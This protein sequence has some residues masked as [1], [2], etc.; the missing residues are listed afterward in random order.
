MEE[1][2]YGNVLTG[3]STHTV[4]AARGSVGTAALQGSNRTITLAAGV[5]TFSGLSYDTAEAM[6]ILFTTNASAVTSATSTSVVVA[7]AA[8]SKL[9]VTQRPSGTATAG[10]AFT[11]QP[12]V[13]EEDQ[14]GNIITTD[15][16]DTVTA[17]RG[18]VGTASLQGSNLTVTLVNGV[19][20]FSGLSYNI[21]ETMNIGFTTNA[22][23]VSAAASGNIAVSP[24]AA[25]QLVINQQPSPTAIAG[26]PFSTQPV[27]YEED[28]YNNLEKG[29]NSTVI[30]AALNSGSGP[31]GGTTTATVSG[32]IAKF[33]NLSDSTA[34][35]ITLTFSSSTLTSPAS[36]PVVVSPVTANKL[37]IH[38]QPSATATAGQAFAIQPVI[39][40]EDSSGNLLTS[41]NTSVVTVS[42]AS[43]NGTL[44]GTKQV[45]AEGG[46]VT[47]AGLSD[48]TA[49]TISLT[50]SGDGLTAGPSTNITV[51]PAAASKLVITQEPSATAT[52]GQPFAT[53]PVIYEEDQYGNVITTDSTDTVTAARGTVGTASLHGSNLTITLVNG[54]ATLSGLS[55][56]IAETMNIAFSTNASGVSAAASGNIAVS[57]AAASQLVINQQPSLAATVGQPFSTQPVIYEEDQYN[58]LEKS[59]DSTV[60]TVKL[61]SGSG[62]LAGATTA[63]VS[64][65][66]AQ[67]TNLAD[68][69][70]ETITLKFSSSTLTSPASNPVVVSPVTANKLLIHLQPS[71][72]ATAGQAFAIQPVIYLEDSSGNLLTSDNTSVVTVSL[73]SGNGT[74]QGTKQVTAEG[75][76]VTFEG[77]SDNTAGTISLS[78]SG[79]GLTA[80]PSTNITVNPAAASKLVITQEP[81]ATAT[82]G[83]VFSTEPVVEEEDQYGNV[84]TTDSTDTVTAARGTVGTASLQGSNLTVTLVNGVASFS[85]LSYN[86]AE[87]MNIG[88][89]TNASG[90]SAA[91]SD[92]IVVSPAAASQLVINQQ[93]SPTA[94]AGQ[95]F[96]TQPVIYE[97]DQYGNLKK[98]D[99]STM[100]TAALYSGS[101][102]LSG[103]TT[104]TVSGGIAKFTNLSDSTAETI[105][106]TFSSS[107]LTSP[108]SNPVVV[109]P[110]TANKLLIHLQPSAT[111][112]AGQAFAIQ[113]VIYLEDSSG[114]LL[115]SDNTSVVT[116]SLA[117]GNGTL[118]GT[119]QVTAE[120]GIVTFAGLSDNTA[121][122]I[123]LTFSGDGLTAGPST[124]ITVNPAAPFQLVIHT[125]P[126]S[127][128]TAGQPFPIGPVI[129][130]LDQYGNLETGDNSTVITASLASGNGPLRGTTTA[131]TV[132]GVASFAGLFDNAAGIISLNFAGAGFTAG[133]SNNVF[134][135]PA[136]AAQLVVQTQPFSSVTAG[137]PLTDPIVIDEEDQYGN[138]ETGDSSTVVTASLAGGGGSLIGTTTATVSGGVASFDNIEDD[139]AGTLS[140]QF[141]AGK[142]PPVI[143]NP[144]T[145]TAA[146]A[147]QITVNRPPSG[148]VAGIAFDLVVDAN[149]PFG[150]LDT[151]YAGPVTIALASGS[152]GAL[153]GNLTVSASGG[154]AT[155]ND[156]VDDMSGSISLDISSGRLT[157]ATATGILVSPGTAAKLIVQSQPSQAA[158]AGVP[159]AKQPVIDEEDQ[160]GN[161]ETSDSSTVVTASV[162]SGPGPL[163]GTLTA[164]VSGGVA[165]FSNLA[166]DLVGALTIGF[167]GTG[168]TRA[169]SVPITISPATA[170][171][172]VIQTTATTAI[173]GQTF[174]TNTV[175][176]EEDEFGNLETSDNSTVVTASLS[177]GSGPL[178]GTTATV[179]GGAATF[180][181]LEDDKAETI[182]LEFTGGGSSSAPSDPIVVSPAA[183]SALM[184]HTQPSPTAIAGQALATEPVIYEEDRFG[185]LETN[186]NSTVITAALSS[187]NGP[188][189]GATAT[190]KGGV[191]TFAKLADDDA[192]A[193]S[194]N[195]VASGLT[196]G[197]SSSVVVAPA[198]ASRLA[199]QTQPSKSATAGQPFATQPIIREEDQ[200]GNLETGDN[201]T[202]IS[203][204]LASGTGPLQGTATATIS[205]GVATFEGLTDDTAESIT[206]KFTGGGLT[207]ITSKPITVSA[208]PATQLVVTAAPPNPIIA[209]QAFVVAVSAEDQ[210]KNVDTNYSGNVTISLPTDPSVVITVPATNGVATFSGLTLPTTAQGGTIQATAG[211][212]KGVGT[213]PVKVT[214]P[215]GGN[216]PPP[217][218]TIIG[219]SVVMLQKKNKKGKPVG[220]AVFEGFKLVFSSAMNPATAGLAGNYSALA[221]TT[222]REKKKIVPVFKPVTINNVVYSQSNNVDSVTL[223]LKSAT[224][225]A[226]GGRITIINTLP[227]GVSSAAGGVLAANDTVFTIL[228]KAKGVGIA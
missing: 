125:Q 176:D 179:S 66:T 207:P 70:A 181:N 194:L 13:E 83:Q 30:M 15:S 99:N 180:A 178:Q 100:I 132:A 110:V 211:G 225:F 22:S 42:L 120:G 184:I 54:V 8:A 79:D 201:G 76:I 226:K 39:Y 206:L 55:Y 153:S 77:L 137:N 69:M 46:I 34:E 133:P 213:A 147:T 19:A 121:G 16:T 204:S 152:S 168:L 6:N 60:I 142:L 57:P 109:S 190:V 123:S 166:A 93:P 198:A 113:P 7:Q 167:T 129:Y 223:T 131:T 3:D 87:T 92:N 86:I 189:T 174:A 17:A 14:Y 145:V 64:S 26:Q 41:D 65:G 21:A 63:T 171:K 140:L 91:A 130:E 151:S 47:F 45:T 191:A 227:D 4:T 73:A 212:L 156:L 72:T 158:T 29:D 74:L 160:F 88:F 94:I 24:A 165:T 141:S 157:Q 61:N 159:L 114:N 59:D 224:P 172:L 197:L 164:T 75:G 199:I 163:Q 221:M 50:F 23:G 33:T 51:N 117:S 58:N 53:Q 135:S 228:P 49:G 218:P 214:P 205:S 185:N 80:G 38:L 128:A 12:I 5:A 208:A 188:L 78:F 43:G 67:F 136:A 154:V 216:T 56:N 155:F 222:K 169:S 62:P 25:S 195:F 68:N 202:V 173:A 48:N 115:T 10:V 18:T 118:Q 11:T 187:G 37:L 143:A 28:Q 2:Q 111:A 219:E 40:L 105:T 44:Q 90:V 122:T 150:N 203:V 220:K 52:A 148:V 119:K 196:A 175:I 102:P 106:L 170:S 85:G 215:E 1:D 89:T 126:S 162:A 217:S 82:A 210:F 96:S 104:V 98:G 186:D 200:F 108:A 177:S 112:T 193:F 27:I 139:T 127:S 209:G 161:L 31:L 20:S 35:T 146:P 81:S 84:I 134:I 144:S 183:A 149:D 95:P 103:T 97:E 36:N 124:N 192:E 32:G 116:V 107:T 101:G 71:A 138:I 182:S 9:V